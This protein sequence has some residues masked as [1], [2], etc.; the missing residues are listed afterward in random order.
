MKSLLA[1]FFC[2]LAYLGAT[3]TTS[4]NVQFVTPPLS[5]QFTGWT[6]NSNVALIQERSFYVL[7]SQITLET[8]NLGTQYNLLTPFPGSTVNVPAGTAV[9]VWLLHGHAQTLATFNGTV[10]F[11]APILGFGLRTVCGLGGVCPADLDSLGHPS[12]AYPQISLG[13]GLELLLGDRITQDSLT[14]ISFR[15]L[16]TLATMDEIRIVTLAVPEP[17]TC[18]AVLVALLL[19]G[20]TRRIQRRD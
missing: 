3:P 4:S 18:A 5:V 17:G 7:P 13:R 19:G 15:M 8:L 2:S 20:W 6:S 14:S 10:D 9:D 12:V 16:N 1:A 11:Q